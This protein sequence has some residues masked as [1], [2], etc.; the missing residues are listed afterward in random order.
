MP[1]TLM[2]HLDSLGIVIERHVAITRI[3]VNLLESSLYATWGELGIELGR[4][5]ATVATSSTR[6]KHFR[7]LP[8]TGL[9]TTFRIIYRNY[10]KTRWREISRC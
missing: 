6:T 2:R 8:G 5:A 4:P 10:Y 7:Q 9:I 3:A 1:R